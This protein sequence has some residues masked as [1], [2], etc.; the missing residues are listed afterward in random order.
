[1]DTGTAAVQHIGYTYADTDQPTAYTDSLTAGNTITSITSDVLFHVNEYI[2]G[3]N[4]WVIDYDN[5]GDAQN[6][7]RTS[8]TGT[9]YTITTGTNRLATIKVGSA[10]NT[11]TTNANG[12]ITGFSSAYGSA[13]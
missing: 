8:L 5:S 2:N 9:T 1:M 10:T 4:H 7:N 11:V 6:G 12:N 3:A 13:G